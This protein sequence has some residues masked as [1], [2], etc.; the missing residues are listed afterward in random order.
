MVRYSF[1]L[2][3]SDADGK[4]HAVIERFKGLCAAHLQQEYE[5]AVIDVRE[6]PD[7]AECDRILATPALVRVSP[8]PRKCV[9][10]DL[11]DSEEVLRAL[12]LWEETAQIATADDSAITT[13]K[14]R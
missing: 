14:P 9:V 10:G 11:A 13:R 5:I 4:D 3:V 12:A 6:R 1:R 2:F 7:L 8:L